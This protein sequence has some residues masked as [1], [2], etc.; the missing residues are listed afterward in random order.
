MVLAQPHACRKFPPRRLRDYR[1]QTKV[2]IL[3]CQFVAAADISAERLRVIL[4]LLLLVVVLLSMDLTIVDGRISALSLV[5]SKVTLCLQVAARVDTLLYVVQ[6][7]VIFSSGCE[8][9]VH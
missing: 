3:V 7:R 6:E 9:V 1:S 8:S 5:H 2:D 4:L